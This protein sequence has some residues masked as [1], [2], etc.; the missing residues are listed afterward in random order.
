MMAPVRALRTH[1]HHMSQ[2]GDH[3]AAAA[4]AAQ[5]SEFVFGLV[6]GCTTTVLA[7]TACTLPAAHP[8]VFVIGDVCSSA[9][10]AAAGVAASRQLPVISP[11]STSPSLS[12]VDYFF[13]TVR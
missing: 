8:T 10:V 5:M 6:D 7:L 2:R 4:A 1:A 3:C 9:S 12:D 11:A 13:R